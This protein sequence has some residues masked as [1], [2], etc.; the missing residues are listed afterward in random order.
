MSDPVK[1]FQELVEYYSLK[2]ITPE[3]MRECR[4]RV[5]ELMSTKMG[6]AVPAKDIVV[7]KAKDQPLKFSC[8][9]Q[10]NRRMLNIL[11]SEEIADPTPYTHRMSVAVPMVTAQADIDDLTDDELR[12][13]VRKRMWDLLQLSPDEL[14]TALQPVENSRIPFGLYAR[15]CDITGKGMNEGWC[16]GDGEAYAA[17]KPAAIAMAK[18]RGYGSLEKAHREGD[19]YWTQ[20]DSLDPD[21][22]YT[23]DGRQMNGKKEQSMKTA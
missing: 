12:T 7:T 6:R 2:D 8:V 21:Y 15:R 13:A 9:D 4:E 18:Q 19:V 14:R 20:W 10:D 11:L 23:R 17:T 16:F 22:H 3:N 5:S 1:T